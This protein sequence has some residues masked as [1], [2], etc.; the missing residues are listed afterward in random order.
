VTLSVQGPARLIGVDNGNPVSHESFKSN[1]VKAFNGLC[2]GIVQSTRSAGAIRIVVSGDG[3][4]PA[5][6]D[7]DSQTSPP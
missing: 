7:L 3:L 1:R 5:E 4:R 2:L 6:I